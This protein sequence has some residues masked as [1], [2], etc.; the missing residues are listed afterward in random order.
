MTGS[1]VKFNRMIEEFV[2]SDNC[3]PVELKL[4][5][6]Y[7]DKKGKIFQDDNQLLIESLI[8]GFCKRTQVGEI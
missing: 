3:S 1:E 8:D 2:K 7:V 6:F 5:F 4:L